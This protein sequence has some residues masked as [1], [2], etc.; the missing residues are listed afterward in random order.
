MVNHAI[1]Q[2]RY[3]HHFFDCLRKSTMRYSPPCTRLKYAARS[4]TSGDTP[5]RGCQVSDSI[6]ISGASSPGRQRSTQ[7]LAGSKIHYSG[8]PS[9]W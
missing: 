4:I 6:R 7:R 8:T 5:S 2:P 9:D 1:P 3:T